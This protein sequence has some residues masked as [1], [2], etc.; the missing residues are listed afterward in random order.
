M[1]LDISWLD[2]PFLTHTRRIHGDKDIE[3]LKSAGVQRVVIDVDRSPK[4]GPQDIEQESRPLADDMVTPIAVPA[5]APTPTVASKQGQNPDRPTV[6][7]EL[8]AAVAIRQQVKNAVSNLQKSFEDGTPIHSSELTPLVD[9]TLSSLERNNQALLSLVHL[10]RKSQKLADHTFGCFCLVLNLALTREVDPEQRE[11]LGLA[12]LLH[13][14]GWVQIPL[15]LMG[16]RKTYSYT[17]KKL[18]QN[19]IALAEKILSQSVIPPLTLRIVAEHHER[20]DGSGYP[21]G[22]KGAQMHPLTQLLAVVDAYEEKVHQLADKPG[23]IPTNAMRSLYVEAEKGLYDL[24]VATTFISMLGVYPV[25]TA[26]KLNTGELALIR[27]V[28]QGFPLTPSLEV[29]YDAKGKSLTPPVFLDLREQ[30]PSSA[31]SIECA[32]DPHEAGVDW[33]CR[34]SPEHGDLI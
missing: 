28:H 5:P 2:S 22:L 23:M 14:A 34:L 32:I 6:K 16:K 13:E 26:V 24:E 21:K 1:K 18:V 3:A 7:E 8:R 12:A 25:M 4:F 33:A 31:R 10:S 9:S 27:E 20:L 19:H 17:E 29:Q 30:E 11:Q 15:Q